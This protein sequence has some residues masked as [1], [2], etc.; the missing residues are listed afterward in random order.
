MSKASYFP[1]MA[2]IY[3][4][5]LK[6]ISLLSGQASKPQL[7]LKIPC[8][9]LDA[10]LLRSN[11]P[12]YPCIFPVMREICGRRVHSRLWAP[13]PRQQSSDMRA[14][15]PGDRRYIKYLSWYLGR[16]L[17]AGILGNSNHERSSLRGADRLSPTFWG[18][19]RCVLCRTVEFKLGSAIRFLCRIFS[20]AIW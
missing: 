20:G 18:R 3:S 13:P 8:S 10:R 12:R 14:S 15:L 11:S 1:L 19:E 7:L 4:L 2:P 16:W 9:G 17:G 5:F 6:R